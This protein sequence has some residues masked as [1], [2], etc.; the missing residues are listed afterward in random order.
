MAAQAPERFSS[1]RD[2][3]EQ[4][5]VEKTAIIPLPH[6]L[7]ARDQNIVGAI[8]IKNLPLVAGIEE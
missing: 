3:C 6:Q 4:G 5:F 8:G 2:L 7:R 1:R